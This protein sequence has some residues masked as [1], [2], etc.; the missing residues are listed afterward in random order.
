M[1]QNPYAAYSNSDS[2][3]EARTSV[4]AIL[5]LVSALS[6]C[7]SFL[8]PFLG[9]FA[10]LRISGSGGRR[11]GAGLAISGIIIG[12]IITVIEIFL[13]MGAVSM[14]QQAAGFFAP[15]A[16]KIIA[17]DPTALRSAVSP[18]LKAQVTDAEW[19]RFKRE[20]TAELGTLQ[21]PAGNLFELFKQYGELGQLMNNNQRGGNMIP[22]PLFGDKGKGVLWVHLPQNARVQTPNANNGGTPTDGILAIAE[23]F[24]VVLP[25][26]KEVWL[27]P[28]TSLPTPGTNP[29]L[30]PPNPS[31]PTS[32]KPSG[33]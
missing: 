10:L 23:N 12:L 20:V 27:V 8:A 30:P 13:I 26:G 32:P 7:L 9:G 11:K 24:S 18:T 17:D 1:S 33:V 25:S 31:E 22:V 14:A 29:L 21:P 3:P 2:L 6:C 4:L 28:Q 15:F 19:T 5:S 16:Q